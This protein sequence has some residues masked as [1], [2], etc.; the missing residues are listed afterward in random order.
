MVYLAHALLQQHTLYPVS[1]HHGSFECTKSRVRIHILSFTVNY[2]R[3]IKIVRSLQS[4]LWQI[5]SGL[6][7]QPDTSDR[8]LTYSHEDQLSPRASLLCSTK[9]AVVVPPEL[10]LRKTRRNL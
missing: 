8:L 1:V 2:P 3:R 4:E 6:A 10:W 5:S 9:P 7:L